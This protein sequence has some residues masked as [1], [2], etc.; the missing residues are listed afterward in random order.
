[1]GERLQRGSLRRHDCS[2]VA[3]RRQHRREVEVGREQGEAA[4]RRETAR[5]ARQLE[6][7]GEREWA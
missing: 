5:R 4:G 1:M 2:A 6:I 3:W 7:E